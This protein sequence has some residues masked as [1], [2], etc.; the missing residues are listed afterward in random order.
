MLA[1]VVHEYVLVMDFHQLEILDN[2]VEVVST[3]YHSNNMLFRLVRK[4]HVQMM[5]NLKG[6]HLDLVGF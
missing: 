2:Q 5:V 6:Y 4:Q 3:R 1:G